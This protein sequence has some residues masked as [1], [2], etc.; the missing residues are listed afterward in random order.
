[1]KTTI[2]FSVLLFLSIHSFSYNNLTVGDPRA[3]WYTSQGTIEEASLTLKPKGLYM[4][5]GLTLTFS[6]R[7]TYWTSVYDS[8]EIVFNF[9]L[10]KEAL[11]IDSWLWIGNDIKKAK[12]LDKWTASSIYE[13]IVKR[14]RDPSILS[15][16][17]ESQYELRIF[18][19]AG[20]ETRKVKITYLLPMVWTKEKVKSTIPSTILTTS[21]YLP[22]N[23]NIYTWTDSIWTNPVVEPDYELTFTANNDSMSGQCQH[24][25]LPSTK[26]YKNLNVCFNSPAKNGIFFSK[27][28]SGLFGIYQLAIF[29]DEFIAS[30][31]CK[32]VAVLIDYDASNS[33]N[34]KGD[35]LNEIKSG[36]LNNL[37]EK[38][39]FNLFFS[40]LSIN[41]I[42]N[43]WLCAS[44]KNIDSVFS[45]LINP[46]SNYSNLPTLLANGIDFIKQTGHNGNIVLISNS[47]QNG[48]YKTANNL[49]N[50]LIA[51]MGSKIP[52]HISDYQTVNA[53]YNYINGV[54]YYGNE[55]F[56]SNLS[57]LS[58][59]SYHKIN[60]GYTESD[61]I[62]QSFKYQGGTINS[63]DLYTS[64]NSG[65]CY[66]RYTLTGTDNMQYINEPVLQVGK[67]KGTYPFTVEF[68]G[69]YNNDI[70]SEKIEIQQK[71]FISADATAEKIWTGQLLKELEAES[72]TNE[73]IND[74]I[75][76]SLDK[77]I[78]SK[79]TSFLCLEDTNV[80]CTNCQGN[81]NNQIT[82]SVK[83]QKE[84]AD[85]VL[86]YPNPFMEQL[87]IEY[88]CETPS[89]V[90]QI[91]VYNLAGMMLY[92][93][94]VDEIV[95]GKN[96]LKWNGTL[97][98]GNKLNPGI[99]FLI[100]KSAKKTVSVKVIKN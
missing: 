99:Y 26:Y 92:N 77:R 22:T 1:M 64:A 6:S 46:L 74:I 48:D 5:Y 13:G 11:I 20:N 59:G 10:P 43:T 50:D 94:N 76:N 72:Q 9:D 75:F 42:S 97:S 2:L 86:V 78:L 52:I 69:E 82:E 30:M 3:S 87:T 100:C 88:Y 21:R 47:D 41:R 79:Y 98:N 44:Q 15:K 62:D 91:A 63:F 19:M 25:I 45:H 35:L 33:S 54:Y 12:L 17:S 49:I 60:Y 85:S 4:E 31:N 80:I 73:V 90:S 8:L 93:F 32:K 61:V 71:D 68:S 37:T 39:S 16:L 40:N 83:E 38:D 56:Y 89:E 7:G 96:S 36:L 67:F 34:S 18:P 27:Y 53:A 23:F 29:P 58:L 28:N 24:L 81:P 65:F 55:Y 66:G 57:R 14:R 95:Q 70:F 51:L 84:N